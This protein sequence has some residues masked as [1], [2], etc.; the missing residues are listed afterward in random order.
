MRTKSHR[1]SRRE[2]TAMKGVSQEGLIRF[3]NTF[4]QPAAP[5]FEI[6]ETPR[7]RIV[8]QPDVPHAGPNHVT[9]IRCTEDE[10]DGVIVE[11]RS[12]IAPRHVPFMWTLDPD[13]EPANF[14]YY[15]AARDVHP[16]PRPTAPPETWSSARLTPAV[17]IEP[18]PSAPRKLAVRNR[19]SALRQRLDPR[20]VK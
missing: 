17:R 15:L 8:L 5:G 16:D 13:T 10:A 19:P 2:N 1:L 12:R 4:R 9:W 20:P 18:H 3:A 14:P 11:V 7:Y 6:V